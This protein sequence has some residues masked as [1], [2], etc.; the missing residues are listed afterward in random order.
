ML[1][2]VARLIEFYWIYVF[3]NGQSIK[4]ALLVTTLNPAQP[5]FDKLD[6]NDLMNDSMRIGN[7]IVEIF[8]Q[9][10]FYASDNLFVDVLCLVSFIIILLNERSS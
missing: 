10:N 9:R 8:R 3:G 6:D 5:F 1:R 7:A 4:T 2:G